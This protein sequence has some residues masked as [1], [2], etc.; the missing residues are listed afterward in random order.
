MSHQLNDAD[1]DDCDDDDEVGSVFL[2]R[3][4]DTTR[5]EKNSQ[6]RIVTYTHV[7]ILLVP[8]RNSK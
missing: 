7:K 8:A 2:A 3:D 1:D 6:L 4:D 5:G